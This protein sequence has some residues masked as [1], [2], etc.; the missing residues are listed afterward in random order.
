MLKA[1]FLTEIIPESV[2]ALVKHFE[3][4]HLALFFMWKRYY[5]LARRLCGITFTKHRSDNQGKAQSYMRP[6]RIIMAQILISLG[7]LLYRI[8][9]SLLLTYMKHQ[10]DNYFNLKSVCVRFLREEPTR[11]LSIRPSPIEFK[12]R[13]R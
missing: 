6:G 2:Q 11:M 9:K 4:L 8:T 12:R 7:I 5:E 1:A 13:C 10:S 3:H